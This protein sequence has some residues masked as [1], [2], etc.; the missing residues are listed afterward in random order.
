MYQYLAFRD[1]MEVMEEEYITMSEAARLLGQE[2]ASNLN[3]AARAG[4][5][6]TKQLGPRARVTT[7]VWLDEYRQDL[8]SGGYRRGDPQASQDANRD[9]RNHIAPGEAQDE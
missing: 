7:R 3:K 6:K 4:R 8:R 9:K 2:D 1:T 5:L